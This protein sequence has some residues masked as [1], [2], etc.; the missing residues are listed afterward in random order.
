MQILKCKNFSK[1]KK[2]DL[3]FGS[4]N[5]KLNFYGNK[6]FSFKYFYFK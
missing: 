2:Y 5:I 4:L 3:H 1:K 6:Y